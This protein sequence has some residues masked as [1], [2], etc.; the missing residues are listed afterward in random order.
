MERSGWYPPIEGSDSEYVERP[1]PNRPA[2]GGAG[3]IPPAAMADA[4]EAMGR[5]RSVS[6]L[7]TGAGCEYKFECFFGIQGNSPER[8]TSLAG[9]AHRDHQAQVLAVR[10]PGGQNGG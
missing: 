8:S 3:S 6:V 2:N 5:G 10:A 1:L 9:I 4:A 7:F